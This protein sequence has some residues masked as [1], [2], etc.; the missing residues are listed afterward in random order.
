[1]KKFSSKLKLSSLLI[2]TRNDDKS[3]I[4]EKMRNSVINNFLIKN[5][6]VNSMSSKN[7]KSSK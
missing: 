4:G 6:I 3:S 7:S 5:D 1:M 2:S